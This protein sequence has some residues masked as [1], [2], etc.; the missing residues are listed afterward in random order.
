M[1]GTHMRAPWTHAHTQ[2]KKYIYQHK[3][4]QNKTVPHCKWG[5]M[6]SKGDLVDSDVTSG[7]HN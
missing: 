5:V 4:K 3:K 7:R 6:R 1:A 2:A